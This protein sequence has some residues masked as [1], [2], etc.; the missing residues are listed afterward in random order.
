[1]ERGA[2]ASS[3]RQDGRPWRTARLDTVE[4]PAGVPLTAVGGAGLAT[5]QFRL[6]GHR[7]LLSLSV[8]YRRRRTSARAP[9]ASSAIVAGSGVIVMTPWVEL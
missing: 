1:M 9:T 5:R 8:A 4:W 2:A 7:L 3:A 6:R